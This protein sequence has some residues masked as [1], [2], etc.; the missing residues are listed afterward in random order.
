MILLCGPTLIQDETLQCLLKGKEKLLLARAYFD[1]QTLVAGNEEINL[2]VFEIGP[3]YRTSLEILRKLLA[4]P[5]SFKVIVIDG[6]S[7]EAI[8]EALHYGADDVFR[9]PYDREL[10]VERIEGLIYTKL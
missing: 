4:N 10:L 2:V 1:L 9:R 8:I 7:Q 3:D 6:N 5:N